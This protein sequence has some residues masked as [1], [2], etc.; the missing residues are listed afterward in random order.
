MSNVGEN[1]HAPSET[2]RGIFGDARPDDAH[3]A[4]I[5]GGQK[6][7]PVEDRPLVNEVKPDDYPA[8]ERED[9]DLTRS[10]S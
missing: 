3:D 8:R 5:G 10:S 9:G 1:R 6:P 7:E 2:P 4:R